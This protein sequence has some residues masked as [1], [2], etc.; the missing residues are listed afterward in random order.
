MEAY[1]PAYVQHNLPFVELLKTM[2]DLVQA[3][4]AS[5]GQHSH[6]LL[7][8]F[9]TPL[10]VV[11]AI[12]GLVLSLA[13]FPAKTTEAK[14]DRAMRWIAFFYRSEIGSDLTPVNSYQYRSVE[15][16]DCIRMAC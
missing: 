13:L 11:V 6:C 12:P 15:V 14:I 3:G 10:N 16:L 5:R 1:P 8:L 2:P 4:F 7:D 9:S